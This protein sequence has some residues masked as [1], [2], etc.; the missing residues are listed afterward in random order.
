MA[1]G[2][3][4]ESDSILAPL[5]GIPLKG[6]YVEVFS[7]QPN[8]VI[9]FDPETVTGLVK[10]MKEYGPLPH[11]DKLPEDFTENLGILGRPFTDEERAR[12]AL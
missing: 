4:H 6:G 8:G 12:L 3:S 11:I 10:T 1:S 9:S 2:T 5:K 7:D